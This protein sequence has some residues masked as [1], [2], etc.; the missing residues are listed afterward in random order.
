MPRMLI[1][2]LTAV[3]AT[4]SLSCER[5]A[6]HPH[7]FVTL[8][9]EVMHHPDGSPRAIR[10]AWTFDEHFSV[11]APVDVKPKQK[12][13]YT[14]EELQ[15]L[16]ILNV[17]SLK[18]YEYFTYVRLDDKPGSIA[19]ARAIGLNIATLRSRCISRFL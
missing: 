10:H 1:P 17:T 13:V 15:P 6:A 7:V 14:R 4:L 5:A 8:R 9:A 19:E 11:Y 18:E 2:I 16:A 12:G 3:V